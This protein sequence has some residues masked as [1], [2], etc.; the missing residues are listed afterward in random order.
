[1]KSMKR[2][3]LR[4]LG[5]F[6][7]FFATPLLMGGCPEFQNQTVEAFETAFRSVVDSALTLFFDQFRSV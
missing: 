4:T 7:L 1:M 2:R 6:S 5:V 3:T